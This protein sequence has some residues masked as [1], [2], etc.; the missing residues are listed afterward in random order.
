MRLMIMTDF[1]QIFDMFNDIIKTDCKNNE[2]KIDQS[3]RIFSS[4]IFV[5][6]YYTCESNYIYMN[7]YTLDSYS[8]VTDSCNLAFNCPS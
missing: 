5:K 4:K 2:C 8:L 7:P 3:K 1:F 6:A